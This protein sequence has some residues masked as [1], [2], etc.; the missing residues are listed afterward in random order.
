MKVNLDEDK[1][2]ID[3]NN[4][5]EFSHENIKKLGELETLFIMQ[6]RE[7]FAFRELMG[8]SS[9]Y[10]SKIKIKQGNKRPYPISYYE[11]NITEFHKNNVLSNELISKWFSE[12]SLEKQI[13]RLVHI[14]DMDHT[15]ERTMF[16]RK[17]MTEVINRI[18]PSYI[19]YVDFVISRILYIV[20]KTL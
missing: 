19:T 2:I 15:T 7:V 12:I 16:I 1:E 11:S 13:L 18:N 9:S 20:Q 6:I 14:S 10:E 5:K 8:V 3:E 4:L 17:Q